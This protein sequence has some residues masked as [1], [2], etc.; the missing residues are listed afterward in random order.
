MDVVEDLYSKK[1][2][3]KD[4]FKADHSKYYII[5]DTLILGG[6]NIEDK[7]NGSDRQGREYQD[8]MIKH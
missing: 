2:I 3:K 1:I 4:T 7:E 6:I 5:D 8:Y